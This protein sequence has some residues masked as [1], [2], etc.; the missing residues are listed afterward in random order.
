MEQYL[1]HQTYFVEQFK[2]K[3]SDDKTLLLIKKR[4]F[5]LHRITME[6]TESLENIKF[7]KPDDL[8]L[9]D[10]QSPEWKLLKTHTDE[11]E[12]GSRE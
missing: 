7:T 1:A 4:F 6:I 5:V 8:F 12:A 10:D 9:K 11:V 3:K 2:E